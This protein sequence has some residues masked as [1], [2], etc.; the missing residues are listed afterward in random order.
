MQLPSAEQISKDVEIALSED[1]GTG[2]V[3]AALVPAA[4][5][6]TARVV[7]RE[8]ALLAGTAWFDQS[9]YQVDPEIQIKWRLADGDKVE[10]RAEICTL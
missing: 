2:D 4:D 9:F 7:C 6:G 10:P 8:A 3:S 5:I 1:I